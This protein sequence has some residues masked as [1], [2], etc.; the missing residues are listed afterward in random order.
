MIKYIQRLLYNNIIKT[1]LGSMLQIE[2]NKT[3]KVKLQKLV[4]HIGRS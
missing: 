4:T 3:H 2:G 1:Q